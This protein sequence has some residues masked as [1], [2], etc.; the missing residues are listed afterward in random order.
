VVVVKDSVVPMQPT[1]SVS[2]SI[3]I[4]IPCFIG[5]ADADADIEADVDV[6]TDVD[7]GRFLSILLSDSL[8]YG[9]RAR[10]LDLTCLFSLHCTACMRLNE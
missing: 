5:R 3:C 9:E 1:S 7:K 10:F 2:I 6:D 4:C 8:R